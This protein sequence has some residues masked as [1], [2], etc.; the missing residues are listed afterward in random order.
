MTIFQNLVFSNFHLNFSPPGE[1]GPNGY[2]GKDG[3]DGIPGPAG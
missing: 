3:N 1:R 2:P